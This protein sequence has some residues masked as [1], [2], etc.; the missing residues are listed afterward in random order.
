MALH[1]GKDFLPP[2]VVGKVTGKAKYAEDFRAEG[3]LFAKLLRSPVPHG[4][5]KS[6]DTFKAQRLPG[7]AAILT[8]D[9]L[10]KLP[11]VAEPM[12]TNEPVYVGEPIAAVAAVDEATAAQAIGLIELEVQPLPFV[13]DPLDS[14]RP[15][16]P[17]ARTEGNV[18]CVN[19]PL[20]TV[21]WTAR[22]FAS[23]G[24]GKLPMG[25]PAEEWQYGDIEAGFKQAHLIV[26][27]TFVT[28]AS[29]HHSMEPRSALA[30]WQG[31]KLYLHGS[32]Q[33][34]AFVLPGIAQLLGVDPANLVFVSEHTGG[35]FGSKG[36][37]Y[38]QWGIPALLAKKAQRPVMLR[39]TRD[40]EHD[41]GRARPGFQGWVKLGF[42]KDG[43]I[44]A[45]DLYIVQSNG[46]YLGFW[47]FRNAGELVSM[48]YQPLNMRWRGIP[49]LTNTPPRTAQRGP[50]ENQTTAAVEPLMDKAARKLS[51]DRLAIRLVNAP[52]P[53]GRAGHE[54]QVLTSSYLPEA[55]KMGAEKFGWTGRQAS[56]GKRNGSKATGTGIGVGFHPAGQSGFDG[57]V[58]IKPDGKLYIH[59]G[60]GNLGTYS[61]AATSR[62]AAEA[63]GMPWEQCEIVF[64][65]SGK[66]VP[67]VLGQFG[68]NTSFTASRAT[69]AGAMD[70]KAKLQE[71]AAQDLGGTP[72][73]YDTRD[74]AV[75][76]TSDPSRKLSFA[77]AAQRAIALGGK[78]S[79][80]ELPKDINPI[81]A[82]SAAALAGQGLVGVAKDTMP[83]KGMIPAFCAGFAQVEVDVETGIVEITD[84]LGVADC[85]TVIHPKSLGNQIAGGGVHGIGMA[86]FEKH[87]HDPKFGIA[88]T[89]GLLTSKLP[90]YL[91]VP[92]DIAWDAVDQPDPQNPV[93][94]KGIGEPPMGAAA[95]AVICAISDALGGVYFNRSPVTLD[96]I[97]NAAE[98]R[99]PSHKPLDVDV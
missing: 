26:E 92:L 54:R 3:M 25:K 10:P 93:G 33:S 69:W 80:Q 67:W 86:R 38:A 90:T 30:Y 79:G 68:S 15:D 39:V 6:L 87:V 49:V 81:T 64:G 17:N 9:D 97:L 22:D 28:Q 8:A 14:L 77:A 45:A 12:L 35:G 99:A 73:Q 70:A 82:R 5:V 72:E 75:F 43:R 41:F 4:K 78:Y 46:P 52:G 51:M 71:I 27:E 34:L 95:A 2:D 88:A 31:A 61:Y 98:G 60:A 29:A 24:Q 16:G 40:E 65:N 85:G 18:A 76:L 74:G 21:K 63:L 37:S 20:Q 96:M 57:L 23:L 48:V 66:G 1:I 47:D 44:A 13:I 32:S 11:P 42:R 19:L 59:S 89:R 84:Y 58:L 36:T 94:A 7:V 62:A 83:R 50:G 56:S 53:D 91:D 55:L